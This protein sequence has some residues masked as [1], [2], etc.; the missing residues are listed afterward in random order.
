M[1]RATVT[2]L[3]AQAAHW[4]KQRKPQ[5]GEPVFAIG[6]PHGLGWTHTAGEISQLRRQSRNAFTYHVIQTSAAIN[7]GSSGGGLYDSAGMLLGI[8]TWTSDKRF[9]EGLGFSIAFASVLDLIPP[10]YEL[11]E[12]HPEEDAP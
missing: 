7:V 9:A 6:N 1:V 11:P 3:E 4:R 2:S 10:R 5:I 8:N 12:N